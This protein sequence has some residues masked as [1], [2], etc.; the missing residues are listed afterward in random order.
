MKVL[1]VNSLT[2]QYGSTR[3]A[4]NIYH[5]LKELKHSVIYLESDSDIKAGDVISVRQWP[6]VMGYLLASLAR[7]CYC[8]F[9]AYELCIIQKITPLT[10]LAILAVKIRGKRL[11]LDWDD[12]D[13]EF[14][15]T[16]F[17]KYLT[18]LIERR[19]PK[20]ADAV[21]THNAYLKDYALSVGC[22]NVFILPQGV[23]THIFDP[24]NYDRQA[25][26]REKNLDQKIVLAYLCTFT[27]GGSRDIDV[28]F[29]AV[30]RLLKECSGLH[31]LLIGAGPL[32]KEHEE[33]LRKAGFCCDYSITGFV[34]QKEA[35]QYLSIADLCLVY[36]RDDLGNR[37]RV[38]LKTLEYLA[39]GKTVVGYIAG[40]LK[41]RVRN[42]Y[43]AVEPSVL[44]F[45]R[46]IKEAVEQKNFSCNPEARR[47]V[48]ENY[49]FTVT[50]DKL[51]EIL[52]VF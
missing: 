37:M 48:V 21:M 17:R 36:M 2:P 8:L 6:N 19:V 11:I 32:Q 4:R 25:L 23:D 38:S 12:L 13:A 47:F 35:A 45:S 30:A 14:Q 26:R 16:L 44:G 9:S 49:S 18:S 29:K 50:K 46:G 10:F 28:V 39:M 5:A 7:A 31:F 33:K 22:K 20:Y 15:T 34:S 42:Y 43:L 41:D 52:G 1:L 51:N 3:R 27:Q 40:E 24:A